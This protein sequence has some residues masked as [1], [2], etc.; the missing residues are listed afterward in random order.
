MTI[1]IYVGKSPYS[2]NCYVGS[3]IDCERR[4]KEHVRF[5]KRGA[6]DNSSLQNAYNKHG[7]L[8]WYI[9]DS[10]SEASYNRDSRRLTDLEQ[11]YL[12]NLP[13]VR[14]NHTEHVVGSSRDRRVGKKISKGIS[15]SYAEGRHS[16]PQKTRVQFNGK[17]H[18]LYAT[19]NSMCNKC[20]SET[21]TR[22]CKFGA[23]GI[24]VHRAWLDSFDNFYEWA[25]KSGWAE[26]LVISRKDNLGDF[27]PSNCKFVTRAFHNENKSYNRKFRF[28]GKIRTTA[29]ICRMV[30]R[31]KSTVCVRLQKGYSIT[32]AIKAK[33]PRR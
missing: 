19:Y 33:L 11:D 9:I 16:K 20:Y 29:E 7:E 13:G 2:W 26:N 23:I 14:Y 17:D 21:A 15:K 30:G 31:S 24:R 6:H 5:L 12:D 32:D 4:I 28:K 3:S 25:I 27:C 18:P 22:Y 8:E 10:I 1:G